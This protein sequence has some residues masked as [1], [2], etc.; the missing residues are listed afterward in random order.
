M[1]PRYVGATMRPAWIAALLAA[2][3]PFAASAQAASDEAFEGKVTYRTSMG[4]MAVE[5]TQF[6]KGKRLRQDI[7]S[8]MGKIVIIF[9]AEAGKLAT[10]GPGQPKRVMSFDDMRRGSPRGNRSSEVEITTTGRRDTIAGHPCEHYLIKQ[11]RNELDICTATGFGFYGAPLELGLGAA[12][13]LERELGGEGLG[14]WEKKLKDTFKDGF[15]PL[16][17]ST[18]TPMGP[19]EMVA[20][21]VE[22]LKLLDYVFEY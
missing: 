1:T 16:K 11:G 18:K 17:I 19:V 8:P 15:F 5:V 20:E 22:R 3:L 21:K 10:T 2:L 7:D 12:G 14:A 4:G 9:D 6:I 13:S